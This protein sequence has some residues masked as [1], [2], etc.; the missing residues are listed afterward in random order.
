MILTVV[1]LLVVLLALGL[2]FVPIQIF[3]D[4]DTGK[5]YAGLGGLAKASFESDEKELLRVRLKVLFYEHCFY[6][7]TKPSKPTKSK[8][9]K[10]KRRIKFRQMVRLLKSFEVKRF[11]LDMDTGDYVVNAKMYPIFVFLNQYVASFHINFENHNRLVVDIRN[12]PYRILKTF[13]NH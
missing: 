12:R 6:P 9:T 11:A 5:Y 3:I 2:L 4:T 10:P 7:L 8:K 13:I 1:I